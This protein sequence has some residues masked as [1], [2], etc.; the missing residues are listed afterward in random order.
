MKEL[1]NKQLIHQLDNDIF[2]GYIFMNISL[3][4]LAIYTIFI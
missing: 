2:Y 1:N 4:S 3:L